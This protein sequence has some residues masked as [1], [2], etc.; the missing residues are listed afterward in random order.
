MNTKLKSA[1]R[2]FA[3]FA[4]IATVTFFFGWGVLSFFEKPAPKFD[5]RTPANDGY[6]GLTGSTPTPGLAR[7]DP[8]APAKSL[9]TR[10]YGL[11]PVEG[12]ISR[13][14]ALAMDTE[15]GL[16]SDGVLVWREVEEKK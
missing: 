11:L 6:F 7:F 4:A 14:P 1:V 16:R 12:I 8:N 2:L 10:W 3:L 9:T 5:P 13:K 15:L